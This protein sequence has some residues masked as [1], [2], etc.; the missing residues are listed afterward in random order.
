MD[1]LIL[2]YDISAKFKV[3]KSSLY[4]PFSKVSNKEKMVTN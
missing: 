2:F 3:K 1:L 4:I